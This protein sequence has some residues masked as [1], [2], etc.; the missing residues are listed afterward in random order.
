MIDDLKTWEKERRADAPEL[1]LISTGTVEA[2]AAQ[3]FE[4]RVLIDQGFKTGRSFG[5][6]G[7]PSGV[8]IDA[9]GNVASRIVVGAPGVLDLLGASSAASPR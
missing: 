2:N 5:A 7:T 3:E 1:V 6:T 4:S 9:D 8:L